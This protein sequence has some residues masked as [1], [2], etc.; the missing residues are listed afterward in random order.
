MFIWTA[1]LQRLNTNE[2]NQIHSS[3]HAFSPDIF[4]MCHKSGQ[5]H[6]HLFISCE[7]AW[8]LLTKS[9][10]C[11]ISPPAVEYSM[12]VFMGRGFR[13]RERP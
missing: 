12:K 9:G 2:M 1:I 11:W 8:K 3:N 10:L 4:V 13:K 5:T 6:S 7:T